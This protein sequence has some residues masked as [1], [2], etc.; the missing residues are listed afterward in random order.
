MNKCIG[1]A[2]IFGCLASAQEDYWRPLFDG[3][4]STFALWEQIGNWNLIN[5][6]EGN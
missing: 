2:L 1:I 3:T 4:D 6:S 5:D